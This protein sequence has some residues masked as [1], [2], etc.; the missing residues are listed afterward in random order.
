MYT[1]T[2]KTKILYIAGSGRSGSTLLSE[3]IGQIDGFFYAGEMNYVV[4][5]GIIENRLC[6]CSLP[7]RT[8][9]LWQKVIRKAFGDLTQETANFLI[10]LQ[11]RN[12]RLRQG[13][14]QLLKV[15]RP[16]LEKYL[17]YMGLLYRAVKTVTKCRVIIDSSKAPV[18]GSVLGMLRDVDLYVVQLIRDPRAVAFSWQRKRNY[19]PSSGKAVYLERLGLFRSCFDWMVI[20]ILAR[21]FWYRMQNR[22][23]L[24][25]YED[26]IANPS[27]HVTRILDLMGMTDLGLSLPFVDEHEVNLGPN[28]SVSGNPCRFQS[29]NVKL[30]L[31][32]EWRKAMNSKAKIAATMLTWPLILSYG[33]SFL[34]DHARHQNTY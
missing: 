30:R 4:K 14:I 33:Y 2:E 31:D 12:V 21:A 18:Y 7:F 28:H 23:M 32:F 34:G 19:Q 26:F 22:Y 3:I 27:H 5:R 9:E 24:L 16:C 15:R 25:R 1:N 13:P 29:G 11:N 17:E 20:N 10:D 6:G 8:C